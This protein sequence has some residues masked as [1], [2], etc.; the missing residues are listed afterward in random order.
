MSSYTGIEGSIP[1]SETNKRPSLASRRWNSVF[2]KLENRPL[3]IVQVIILGPTF[4]FVALDLIILLYFL[5]I[6]TGVYLKYEVF[7][8]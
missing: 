6:N 4:G 2:R 5:K 8:I 1:V 7:I 3:K